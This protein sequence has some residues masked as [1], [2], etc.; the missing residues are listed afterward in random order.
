VGIR[1]WWRLFGRRGIG[2]R[3]IGRLWLGLACLVC[4]RRGRRGR[5]GGGLWVCEVGFSLGFD[6]N[7]GQRAGQLTELVDPRW[8]LGGERGCDDL[9]VGCGG[10]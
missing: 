2:R 6:S 10:L 7:R 1:R 8:V 4:R 3:G 9:F 5:V